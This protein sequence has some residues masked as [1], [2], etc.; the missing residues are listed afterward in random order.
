MYTFVYIHCIK[1]FDHVQSYSYS[2]LWRGP[3]IF[4][5]NILN[6]TAS[7]MSVLHYLAIQLKHS[8]SY[9]RRLTVPMQRLVILGFQLSG[10][11]LSRKHGL[12][13]FVH[14]QLRYAFYQSS[15]T[16]E[17]EWLCVDIDGYKIVNIYKLP[18]T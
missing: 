16:L 5:L 18:P 14:E 8:S 7:K 4:Q 9:Y 2:V 3:T 11:S 10:S 13:T 15:P 12:I 17:I 1:C 6:L